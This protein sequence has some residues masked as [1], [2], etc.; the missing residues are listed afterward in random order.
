MRSVAKA[1]RPHHLAVEVQAKQSCRTTRS[2]VAGFTSAPAKLKRPERTGATLLL[3]RSIGEQ[4]GVRKGGLALEP[5]L[6]F[7]GEDAG[8]EVQSAWEAVTVGRVFL[9][10]AFL[11]VARDDKRRG[12]LPDAGGTKQ[13]TAKIVR[14]TQPDHLDPQRFMVFPSQLPQAIQGRHLVHADAAGRAQTK[15][16]EARGVILGGREIVGMQVS[17]KRPTRSVLARQY[18]GCI[19]RRLVLAAESCDIGG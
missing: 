19:A 9:L 14:P 1:Q 8:R 15:M 2:I 17:G 13:G 3:Q 16:V 12:R 7:F 6:A 5:A 11:G 10:A 4:A 18:R